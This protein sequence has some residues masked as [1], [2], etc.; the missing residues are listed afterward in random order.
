MAW[1]KSMENICG[2]QKGAGRGMRGY[3]ISKK[4][5]EYRT[6]VFLAIGLQGAK[7]SG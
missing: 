4:G 1:N 2:A 5:K 6:V 7:G 3:G